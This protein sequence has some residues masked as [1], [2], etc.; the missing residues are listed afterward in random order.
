[1]IALVRNLSADFSWVLLAVAIAKTALSIC[2]SLC[3]LFWVPH[4]EQQFNASGKGRAQEVPLRTLVHLLPTSFTIDGAAQLKIY[5]GPMLNH[6]FWCICCF[7][8]LRNVNQLT[9]CII[10]SFSWA[11]ILKM[12]GTLIDHHQKITLSP[13]ALSINNQSIDQISV[14]PICPAKPGSVVWWLNQ[15]SAA[16]LMKQ[17]CNIDGSSGV[18]VSIRGRQSQRRVLR[19]FLKDAIEAA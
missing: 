6:W 13:T 17:F 14:A 3:W 10:S 19:R 18:L 9:K 2:C 4:S 12:T 11:H 1:M 8:I 15:W 7:C 16:K 5:W